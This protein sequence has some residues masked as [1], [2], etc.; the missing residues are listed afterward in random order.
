M[1]E[2]PH[3][4]VRTVIRLAF[5]A[6]LGAVSLFILRPFIGAITWATM[7]AVATW[8]VMRMLER[9]LWG[10]R[11]LAV[12]VMTLA[13]LAIIV[14]PFFA[15][16]AA[17]FRNVYEIKTFMAGLPT[18]QLPEAPAWLGRVPVVGARAAQSWAETVAAGAPAF[19]AKAEPYV[20]SVAKWLASEVGTVGD[21]LIQFLLTV[22][23]TAIMFAT[24]EK[25]VAGLRAFARRVAG[26]YGDSTLDLAGG[27]I[28]GVAMGVVVTA[29]VQSLFAGLGL[30]IGGVPFAPALTALMFVLAIAQI[31]P[32]PVL[33]LA[34]IYTFEV[35]GAGWG[36]FVLIWSSVAGTIDNFLRP[37]LIK[38]GADLPLLL[39]MAG[40]IGGLLSLGLMGVF[41]GPVL[42]AVTYTLLEAWVR[43][44]TTVNG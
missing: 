40:V 18:Y 23:V 10:K 38:R 34:V 16:A 4:L 39:I 17:I 20:R 32:I 19:A 6:L 13:F 25:A 44:G 36:T 28:R 37:V 41:V 33:I 14:V 42:L 43:A 31:G 9:R 27:A 5:I 2:Q 7:I 22:L 30:F 11:S 24:G 1:P 12:T 21:F 15:A 29:L 35:H 3:D 26:K 8:P